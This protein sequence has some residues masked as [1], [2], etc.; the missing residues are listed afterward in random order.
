MLPIFICWIGLSD[1][2][3]TLMTKQELI[4]KFVR[5]HQEAM[6]YIDNLADRQ[7]SHSHNGKWTAGQ[8][9]QHILLTIMPFS[10]VL[11]SKEFIREKFGDIDR[12]TWNYATVLENYSKTSL[13]SPGQFLPE[14]TIEPGQKE[15]LIADIQ[16]NLDNIQDEWNNYS[17]NELDK[18]TLPHPL[19]GKLTIREMFYL[20]AYHPL[21][22]LKQIRLMLE[23]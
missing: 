1:T 22:H 9:L 23:P 19:L 18:L 21:H 3:W 14:D 12:P 7:F 6:G 2:I 15:Q 20:M 10:K 5:N 11:P 4:G 8:Q 13:Q 16:K 17:E